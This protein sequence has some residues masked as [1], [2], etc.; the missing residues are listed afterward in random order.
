MIRIILLS[1]L[2]VM[3]AFLMLYTLVRMVRNFY[4]FPMPEFLANLINNPLRRRIQ[5]PQEMPRHHGIQPW[6]VHVSLSCRIV[7]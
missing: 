3:I 5:A 4:K 6:D 1:I 2:S 7:F